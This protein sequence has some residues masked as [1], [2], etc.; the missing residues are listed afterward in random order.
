MGKY[1]TF[2]MTMLELCTKELRYKECNENIMV[3]CNKTFK[4]E[5]PESLGKIRNQR[6]KDFI[7]LCLKIKK[8][9]N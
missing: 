1:G 3:I 8:D 9:P 2:G 7:L 6:L 5:M 4:R